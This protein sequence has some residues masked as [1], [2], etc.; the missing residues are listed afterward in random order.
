MGVRFASETAVHR[1]SHRF[2]GYFLEMVIVMLVSMAVFGAIVSL[3][4][5]A[6]GH[7]NLLHYAALRGLLMSIYMVVGMALWMRYRCHRWISIVEMSAAMLLPYVV[8]VGPFAAGIIG[9]A[10]FLSSMHIL[11]LPL[12]LVAMLHRRAEYTEDHRWHG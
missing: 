1:N 9:K 8:L 7:A 3:V 11:M 5:A 6:L 10:A 2:W 12:M 4:F